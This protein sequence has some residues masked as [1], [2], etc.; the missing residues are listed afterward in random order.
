MQA[1]LALGRLDGL[2]KLLESLFQRDRL[3]DN[4]ASANGEENEEKGDSNEEEEEEQH[5]EAADLVWQAVGRDRLT[6]RL[7][8][9]HEHAQEDLHL[10]REKRQRSLKRVLSILEFPFDQPVYQMVDKLPQ[11]IDQDHR[12][13]THQHGASELPI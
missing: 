13:S 8:Q 10:P 11:E 6:R 2:S 3:P 9:T 7:S 12:H 1:R 4:E 5:E